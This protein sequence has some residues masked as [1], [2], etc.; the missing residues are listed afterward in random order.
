MLAA[1]TRMSDE[2]LLKVFSSQVNEYKRVFVRH[3]QRSNNF[4]LFLHGTL[5]NDHVNIVKRVWKILRE[6]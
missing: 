6:L 2:D 5:H 1:L 3:V 4:F